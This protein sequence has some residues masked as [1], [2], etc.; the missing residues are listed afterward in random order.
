MKTIQQVI[1]RAKRFDEPLIVCGLELI[2]YAISVREEYLF[3]YVRSGIPRVVVEDRDENLFTA[4]TLREYL[5]Y[6]GENFFKRMYGNKNYDTSRYDTFEIIRRYIL[7]LHDS[8]IVDII[9]E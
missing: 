2:D 7:S 9:D 6:I 5:D 3:L 1:E 4:Y 8:V